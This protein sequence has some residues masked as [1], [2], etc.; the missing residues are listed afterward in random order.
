[1]QGSVE[2]CELRENLG[3]KS[4]YGDDKKPF[5]AAMASTTPNS[6]GDIADK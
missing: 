2:I 4:K 5:N 3:V 6:S 1:M